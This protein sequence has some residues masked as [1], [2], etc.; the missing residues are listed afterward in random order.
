MLTIVPA[1]GGSK[2]VPGKNLRMLG[3]LPLIAHVIR[4]AKSSRF[5]MRVVCATDCDNIAEA[6]KLHGAEIPFI[7]PS[8]IAGDAVPAIAPVQHALRHFDDLGWREDIVVALHPTSPFLTTEI[9]DDALRQMLE[10]DTMDAVVGVRR[11]EHNHP[12]VHMHLTWAGY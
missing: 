12:F 3:G 2:G 4:A 5:D 10:D 9:I 8:E 6:A 1:R 7:R 11:I